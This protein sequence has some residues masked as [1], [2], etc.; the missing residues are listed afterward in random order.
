MKTSSRQAP[1]PSLA[2]TVAPEDLRL[3][4]LI[5]LL[6]ETWEWP[7]FM[8]RMDSAALPPDEPVRVRARSRSAGLP[9]KVEAICLPF[10]F[11]EDPYRQFRTL[12][13]RQV[14]IVRLEQRYA[15]M[16]WK[17]LRQRRLKVEEL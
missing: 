10:V 2:A 8:W 3:G 16:V 17:R 15:R 4:D 12:D 5:A 13:I 11:T 14:E 6:N 1:P 9:L 7:S